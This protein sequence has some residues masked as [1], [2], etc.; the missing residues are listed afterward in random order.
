M[1]DFSNMDIGAWLLLGFGLF[2]V[3]ILSIVI[4]EARDRCLSIVIKEARDRWPKK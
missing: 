2:M 4:K 3:L 1:M